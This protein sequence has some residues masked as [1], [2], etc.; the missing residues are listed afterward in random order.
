MQLKINRLIKLYKKGCGLV[1]LSKS[2]GIERA[3]LRKILTQNGVVIRNRSQAVLIKKS[4][5][6]PAAYKA[7]TIDAH[8]K[9]KGAKQTAELRLKISEA[10]K[11]NRP[12]YFIGAGELMLEKYL[13]KVGLEVTPQFVLGPYNIDFLVSG[14][15]A[16]ELRCKGMRPHR[17]P[18][19][20]AKIKSL[21]EKGFCLIYIFSVSAK[22]LEKCL[23]LAMGDI[24]R[25][26]SDLSLK[27]QH[28]EIGCYKKGSRLTHHG[29]TRE[30]KKYIIE[31]KAV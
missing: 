12:S 11:R 22:T 16:I 21:R 24:G 5:L 17:D 30:S 29:K 13:R 19:Q 1:Q 14:R 18:G 15:V 20:A 8:K 23:P 7:L 28:F 27:D 4:F 31:I 25:M 6:G 3:S 26:C 2:E 9:L 10:R